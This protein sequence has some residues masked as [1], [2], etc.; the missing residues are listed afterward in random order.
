[1]NACCQ[2]RSELS[3][4]GVAEFASAPD[5]FVECEAPRPA[6][7]YL[8][9]W[10]FVRRTIDGWT[11]CRGDFGGEPAMSSPSGRASPARMDLSGDPKCLRNVA[12]DSINIPL[13]VLRLLH[14]R[15]VHIADGRV[16]PLQVHQCGMRLPW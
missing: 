9:L 10:R 11:A 13:D 7:F 5:E 1:M 8:H 14:E 15:K 3:M 2:L 16:Y 4:L 12:D 6:V